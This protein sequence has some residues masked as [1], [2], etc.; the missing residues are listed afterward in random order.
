VK[1]TLAQL[2]AFARIVDT[3]SFK[4]AA[5]R[6]H[7]TQPTIS[8]R[9]RE[10]ESALNVELFLRQGPRFRLTAD[11]H[12]LVDFAR[13]LLGTADELK[14]QFTGERVLGGVVRL[15]VPN[16]FAILC[17]TDLLRELGVRFPS[18]KASLYVNDSPT[19][20]H[21]LDKQELDI[22]ILVEPIASA[23]VRRQPLGRTEYSW[24]ASPRLRLP[25]LIRP[26]DLADL[27]VILSPPPSRLYSMVMDWFSSAKV[28]PTRLSTC[29][30][31]ALTID[32]IASGLAVGV[33]PTG[34]T[35]IESEKGRLQ[36]LTVVP[37][38]PGHPT[39]ICYQ[40]GTL[41]AGVEQ[42]TALMCELIS[43]RRLY[44]R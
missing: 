1:F 43:A 5:A 42:V 23:G 39:S 41:G 33:L 2:E 40:T 3:G 16:L 9:I 38:L 21:M 26:A 20:A 4:G 30:N 19:L 28:T 13:R 29:N 32:T 6:L 8:Q 11:G 14:A 25:R 27:H 15:G 12:A 17:M 18:L 35:L 37:Q 24:M 7:V 22:A 31:F 10:L 36:S 44:G 34:V